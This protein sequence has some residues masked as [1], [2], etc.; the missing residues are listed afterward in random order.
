MFTEVTVDECIHY[1]DDWLMRV[2]GDGAPHTG[3]PHTSTSNAAGTAQNAARPTYLSPHARPAAPWTLQP[4]TVVKEQLKLSM[5]TEAMQAYKNAR[6]SHTATRRIVLHH[7]MA[8]PKTSLGITTSFKKIN[9][10]LV[11][12]YGRRSVS[13]SD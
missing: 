12:R 5:N 9:K 6:E 8:N 4:A 11:Q 10:M 2:L 7:A 13:S 3:A 1:D